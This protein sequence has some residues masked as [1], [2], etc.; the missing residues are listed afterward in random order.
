[1]AFPAPRKTVVGGIGA[2]PIK[3]MTQR[4]DSTPRKHIVGS[5]ARPPIKTT[6]GNLSAPRPKVIA[7][8]LAAPPRKITP[9]N[10][11]TGSNGVTRP[12]AMIHP[13]MQRPN[14]AANPRF[15]TRSLG[16][17][18]G[19]LDRNV[20]GGNAPMPGPAPGPPNAAMTWDK[21]QNES[22]ILAGGMGPTAQRMGTAP[23]PKRGRNFK[24]SQF[25]GE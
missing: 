6:V 1:M 25:F 17:G 21:P 11:G 22:D 5:T 4:T 9:G 12:A 7:G 13:G 16:N 15:A 14:S 3:T 18:D 8:N 20:A 10:L 23:R 2:T 19:N 24:P